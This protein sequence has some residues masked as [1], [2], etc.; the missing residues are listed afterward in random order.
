MYCLKG[1]NALRPKQNGHHVADDAFKRIFLT[2]NVRISIEISLKF[3]PT[4]PI[5]NILSLVQ[6]IAW[7]R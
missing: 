6:I 4:R 1:I 7:R 3:V 2:E 5:N